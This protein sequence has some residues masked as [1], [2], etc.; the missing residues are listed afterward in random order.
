MRQVQL[1]QCIRC[2]G[3]S[4]LFRYFLIW[5]LPRLYCLPWSFTFQCG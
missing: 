4:H 5:L 2:G 3:G 1:V